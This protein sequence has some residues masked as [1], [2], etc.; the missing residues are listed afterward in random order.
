MIMMDRRLRFVFIIGLSALGV[1]EAGSQ[2]VPVRGTVRDAAT[3]APVPVAT[4]ESAAL[5]R[6]VITDDSGRFAIPDLPA[7]GARLFV[8][9]VGY[10]PLDTIVVP[11][12]SPGDSLTLRLSHSVTSLDTLQVNA[13]AGER[14]PMS[15]TIPEFEARRARATGRFV[16][17]AEL[18]KEDDRVLVDVLRSRIPGVL[19]E[20]TGDGVHAYNPGQQPPGALRGGGARKC[21]VQVVVDGNSIYQVDM[22]RQGGENRPPDLTEYQ[23]RG[24]DGIEY[25]ASPSRT[26]AELRA[27]GA[28]CGTLVFWTRRR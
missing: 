26:P 25:Y 23:T 2:V 21:Y 16:T 22:A 27:P 6:I 24:L 12:R 4:I 9:H 19:F 20:I 11:P 10:A 17:A 14:L 18:R 7:Q 28:V 13:K 8:R 15:A 1:H 3:G 5:A